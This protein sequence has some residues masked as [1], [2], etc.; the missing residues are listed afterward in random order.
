VWESWADRQVWVR[1]TT[2]GLV[3]RRSRK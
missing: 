1:E 2:G 3:D